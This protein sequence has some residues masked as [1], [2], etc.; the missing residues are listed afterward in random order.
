[1]ISIVIK[2]NRSKIRKC[3]KKC[4]SKNSKKYHIV[5]VK[6]IFRNTALFLL[7]KLAVPKV[8]SWPISGH[9]FIF[10]I[11]G[12]IKMKHWLKYPVGNYLLKVNNRN[13]RARCDMF[14]VNNKDRR[15]TSVASFCCLVIFEHISHLVLVFLLLTLNM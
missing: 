2:G 9:C 12:G 6:Y 1:M 4:I 7:V 10:I 15:T 3:F 8:S 11:S 5:V 14:K 13:T